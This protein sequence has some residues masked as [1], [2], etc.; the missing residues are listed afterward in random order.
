LNGEISPFPV[1]LSNRSIVALSRE[2]FVLRIRS[3]IRYAVDDRL[4]YNLASG[5]REHTPR[6]GV[7]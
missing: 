6:R 5:K 3:D 1:Q 4:S 7:T 2:M